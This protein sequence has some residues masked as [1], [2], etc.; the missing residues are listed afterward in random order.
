M[1]NTSNMNNT[2]N[3]DVAKPQEETPFP[4]TDID[5]YNLSITDDQFESHTWENLK[6]IIANNRLETLRR[7]PSDLK[8]YMK[9]STKTKKEYGSIMAFVMKE[10]LKWTPIGTPEIGLRF[11]FESPVPFENPNDYKT[12]PNDWPYGLDYGITHLI[13]WLKNRLEVQPP[14]GDL[15]PEARAQVNAFI[16]K[17]FA[18]PLAELTG[19]EDNIIWFKNWVSL[20]SVPGIDHIHVLIRGVA[21][22]TIDENWTKGEQPLQDVVEV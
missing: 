12:M 21:K 10:R 9:W 5:R 7:W 22:S 13:V 11:D 14:L 1:D 6:E 16:D 18:K 3:R 17:E 4:L 20:Q 8:R 15:T 19:E 2:V